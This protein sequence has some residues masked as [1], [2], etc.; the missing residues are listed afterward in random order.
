MISAANALMNRGLAKILSIPN[1][2]PSSLLLWCN[3]I[4]EWMKICSNW[5]LLSVFCISTETI[6]RVVSP[7]G[8]SLNIPLLLFTRLY[9]TA[10]VLFP[11]KIMILQ[12]END[13][14]DKS[15]KAAAILCELHT[16]MFFLIF[17]DFQWRM[18][19]E[20]E[21]T[22]YL[23]QNQNKLHA[24][25]VNLTKAASIIWNNGFI[26]N[27]ISDETQQIFHNFQKVFWV[28]EIFK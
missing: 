17:V 7:I 23:K 4:W 16:K 1:I 5:C 2:L 21:N 6:I 14:P 12:R 13:Q 22:K 18:E 3:W 27:K 11:A 9:L 19:A 24:T 25:S 10:S 8:I 26:F 15:L 28:K 20:Q